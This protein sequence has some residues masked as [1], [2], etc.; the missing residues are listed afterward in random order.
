ML[1]ELL[2]HLRRAALHT[3][4]CDRATDGGTDL[5]PAWMLRWLKVRGEQRFVHSG[6]LNNRRDHFRV[7]SLGSEVRYLT[8]FAAIAK[9]ERGRNA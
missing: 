1:A 8:S 3:K 7:A 9:A 4:H 5:S 2:R 6:I